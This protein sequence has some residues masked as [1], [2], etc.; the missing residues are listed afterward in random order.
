MVFQ[1]NERF[2]SDFD[3]VL[4]MLSGKDLGFDMLHKV[5]RNCFEI[6]Y[7][8]FVMREI[9]SLQFSGTYFNPLADTIRQKLIFL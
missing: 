6:Y 1:C 2:K 9:G 3:T 5:I 7:K 8:T 4:N